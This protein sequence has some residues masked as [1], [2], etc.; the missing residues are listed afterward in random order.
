MI[1]KKADKSDIDG[2]IELGKDIHSQQNCCAYNYKFDEQIAREALDVG[3]DSSKDFI[4]VVEDDLGAIVGIL[5]A[6]IGTY[7][8]SNDLIL[9]EALWHVSSKLKNKDRVKLTKVL[10]KLYNHLGEMN[11]VKCI[12]V[13][14]PIVFNTG[15]WLRKEGFEEHENV[16]RRVI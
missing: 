10:F 11:G 8:F 3:I 2:I 12:F 14:S 7:R 1:L 9:E 4:Y 5:W 16:Y 15:K 6:F 13:S